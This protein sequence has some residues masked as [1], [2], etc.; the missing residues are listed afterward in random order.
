MN[1]RIDSAAGVMI[2]KIT[3]VLRTHKRLG[4]DPCPGT[5]IALAHSSRFDTQH[6]R[7]QARI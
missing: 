6:R 4:P 3:A 2:S 7:L 1:S 5:D